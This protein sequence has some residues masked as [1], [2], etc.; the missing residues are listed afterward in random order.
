MTKLLKNKISLQVKAAIIIAL[1]TVMAAVIAIM[2]HMWQSQPLSSKQSSDSTTSAVAEQIAAEVIAN[3]TSAE[4]CEDA[5]VKWLKADYYD[6]VNNLEGLPDSLKLTRIKKRLQDKIDFYRKQLSGFTTNGLFLKDLDGRTP[7]A[8]RVS[9]I[10]AEAT[11]QNMKLYGKKHIQILQELMK[12]IEVLEGERQS[13][14]FILLH[15][16]SLLSDCF[17]KNGFILHNNDI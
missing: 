11:Y 8:K 1:A 15:I 4:T 5:L 9:S 17:S 2:P 7:L 16:R 13:L 3:L 6:L 14:S 10:L 12:D